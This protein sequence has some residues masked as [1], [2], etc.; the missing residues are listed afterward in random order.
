MD[1]LCQKIYCRFFS[2]ETEKKEEMR[3]TQMEEATKARDE[4]ERSRR[5][6]Q[7]RAKR[8]EPQNIVEHREGA[9]LWT[10]EGDVLEQ[11][12][13]VP[14]WDT[15]GWE[16]N[17]RTNESGNARGITAA[18]VLSI[19]ATAGSGDSQVPP[20]PFET[21]LQP[22]ELANAASPPHDSKS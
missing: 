16:N 1:F 11:T 14:L 17:G 9:S 15:F 20:G 5:E 22:L 4:Y 6:Q 3:A 10:R 2:E 8:V 19:A 18:D 13:R 7:E 12:E 21:S